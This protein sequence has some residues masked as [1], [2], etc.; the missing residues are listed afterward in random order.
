M[1]EAYHKCH[2][3]P[4][5]VTELKEVSHVFWDSLPQ[6]Q[7]DKAAKFSKRLDACVAAESGHL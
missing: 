5:T 4:K 3:K 1:L 2:P 6:E 7:T